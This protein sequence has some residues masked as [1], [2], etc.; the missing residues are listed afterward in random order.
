V[1]GQPQAHPDVESEMRFY[2]AFYVA[3]GLAVLRVAPRADREPRA[4]AAISAVLF[5]AGVARALAWKAT[6][7]PQPGQRVLLAFELGLPPAFVAA[8]RSA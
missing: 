8:S 5:G 6:G 1:L 4:V 2:S 7:A 3:Y